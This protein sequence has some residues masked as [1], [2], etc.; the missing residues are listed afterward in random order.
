MQKE[1]REGLLILVLLFIFEI[2]TVSLFIE[3][4]KKVITDNNECHIGKEYGSSNIEIVS[5]RH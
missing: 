5:K 3:F 1:D 2:F 4:G